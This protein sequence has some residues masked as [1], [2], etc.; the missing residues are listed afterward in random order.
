MTPTVFL[1]NSESGF[2]LKQL[3]VTD[4]AL[5]D[6][7]NLLRSNGFEPKLPQADFPNTPTDNSNFGGHHYE[8][9][10][11]PCFYEEAKKFAESRTHNGEQGYLA[12]ILSKEED[13]FLQ[14]FLQKNNV[15]DAWIGAQD[16]Q[17]EGLWKW[18]SGHEKD[19]SFWSAKVGGPVP[20]V[21]SNWKQG[22][23]NNANDEDCASLSKDG[24]NDATCQGS[25]LSL[26]VE[27]GSKDITSEKSDL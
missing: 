8:L 7:L 17:E 12:T 14:K 2:T 22:E 19:E 9:F 27:F 1:I 13:E 16:A 4:L 26:L 11:V 20:D 5:P 21:Y 24:W 10:D 6:V 15:N 18:V 23:P 25:Q 3:E